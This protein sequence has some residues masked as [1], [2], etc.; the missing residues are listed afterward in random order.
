M[1]YNNRIKEI[2]KKKNEEILILKNELMKKENL[3][4]NYRK[5]LFVLLKVIEFKNQKNIY[6][7]VN[8]NNFYNLL[9]KYILYMKFIKAF[10][11]TIFLDLKYFEI[12]Q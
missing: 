1:K 9:T 7:Y 6:F 10:K 11:E 5:N 4:E 12:T 2:L 8:E 3:I